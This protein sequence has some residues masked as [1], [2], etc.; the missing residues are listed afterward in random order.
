MTDEQGEQSDAVGNPVFENRLMR[1]V[2]PLAHGANPVECREAVLAG[3]CRF[4]SFRQSAE[5]A[6]GI[7]TTGDALALIEAGATRLGTS[8]GVE[9]LDGLPGR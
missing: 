1:R 9:L 7:R 6:P 4:A 8:A 2:R 3:R 5:V